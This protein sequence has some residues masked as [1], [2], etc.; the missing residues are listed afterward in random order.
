MAVT[1]DQYERM[2]NRLTRLEDGF[3]DLITAQAYLVSLSQVNQLMTLIQTQLDDIT[4]R[5]SELESRVTSIE[6]EPLT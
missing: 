5:T 3:N 1:T 6:E 2:L 4:T